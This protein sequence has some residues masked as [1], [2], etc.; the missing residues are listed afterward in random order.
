MTTP[1]RSGAA[2]WLTAGIAGV[3]LLA[4]LLLYFLVLLP[5]RD[6]QNDPSSAAGALSGREQAAVTAAATTAANLT[7]FRRAHFD[8][9]FARALNSTTGT[10]HAQLAGKKS[11][12]L[13]ALTAGKFDLGATV[14]HKAL[15]GPVD[16][17]QK[18]Y[19]VLVTV[20]GYKSTSQTQQVQQNLE[21]TMVEVK[22]KWVAADLTNIALQ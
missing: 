8:A 6:D 3:V 5:D 9:D 14:S 1:R 13:K 4:L 20:N 2:P 19:L 7:S 22:S 16:G 21:L 18:G 15:E 17:K 12:T 11:V 10:L